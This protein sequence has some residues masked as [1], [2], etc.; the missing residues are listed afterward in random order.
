MHEL[1]LLALSPEELQA[2]GGGSFGSGRGGGGFSGGGGD[3]DGIGYLVYMLVRLAL[4]YPALGVPLL[5]GVGVLGVMGSRNGWWKH[6]ERVIRRSG[7]ARR[8][9]R[10]K[11]AIETLKAA[12]PGF[13]KQAFFARVERAFLLAQDSWCGQNLE[14]LRAFVSDGVFER[15]SLQIEEQRAEGW[16]Q[17]MT[18]VAISSMD[19]AGVQVGKQFDTLTIRIGFKANIDRVDLKDGKPLPGTKLPAMHFA[20]CWSFVRRLGAKTSGADGLIEGMCPNCGAELS[21]VQ[22]AHC[23]SCKALVRSGQFDWVL[24]EIT[25]ASEWRAE[26]EDSVLGLSAYT[27]SDPGLSV[28]LL[29]DRASVAFWRRCAADWRGTSEPLVRVA[30]EEFCAEYQHKLNHADQA[31]R[32][33]WGD[34]AV[35]SVST[36]GLFR[37]ESV[38]TALVNVVWDGRSAKVDREG[39]RTL[40]K[41]RVLARSLFVFTRRAGQLSNTSEALTTAICTTCG[42]HDGG[43][44]DPVCPY[45]GSARNGGK[46]SWM[47]HAVWSL[48]SEQARRLLGQAA[49]AAKS[50]A[51]EG[52]PGDPMNGRQ[53]SSKEST[54]SSEDLLIWAAALA[55]SDGEVAAQERRAIQSLARRAQMSPLRVDILLA[56]QRDDEAIPRPRDDEQARRWLQALVEL[57]MVDEKFTKAERRFI[58]RAGEGLGLSRKEIKQIVRAARNELFDDAREA[59]HDG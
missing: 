21:L 51:S 7:S 6:Q 41:Q 27:R 22:S 33:Y 16:R 9:R 48:N 31:E 52:A 42:A 19:V 11:T 5:I 47:L 35:G 46:S 3:G 17:R 56:I 44:T 55:R 26:G 58:L 57:A 53:A 14:P 23:A 20:E 59:L 15:F 2:G 12:D 39:R 54:A 29:E 30:D 13:D 40:D 28:Q 37:G 1:V 24:A 36:A 49:A 34:C 8:E 25:Q 50:S 10:T 43:G 38:D 45:C 32:R 18:S 4:V